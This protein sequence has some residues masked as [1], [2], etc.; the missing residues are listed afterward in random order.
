MGS[1]IG[2]VDDQGNLWTFSGNLSTAVVYDLSETGPDGHLVSQT[3]QMPTM[4]IS[5]RG[6]ADLAYHAD[7][8]TFFGVAHG[9]AN[10]EAGTLVSIDISEVALAESQVFRPRRSSEPLLR[11]TYGRASR[12]VPMARP[13]LTRMAT[14]MPV[15]TT[16][17]M[18]ST[19][20]RQT[21]AG[22]T[23]S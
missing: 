19:A 14:C 18:I 6:L 23:R 12:P 9:G 22:S 11:A 8:Q 15:P 4:G 20:P 3:I 16:Q 17:I 10:G 21:R 13:S 5:T 2:D 7:T 1:Y